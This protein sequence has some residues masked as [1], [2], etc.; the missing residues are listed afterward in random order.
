MENLPSRRCIFDGFEPLAVASRRRWR[1][2]QLLLRHLRLRHT[3]SAR[4]SSDPAGERRLAGKE[5]LGR[6]TAGERKYN[7]LHLNQW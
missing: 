4:A 5:Q 3:T 2:F 6:F 7:Q 1:M